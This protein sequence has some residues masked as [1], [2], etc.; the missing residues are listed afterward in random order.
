MLL[1]DF[2]NLG[3]IVTFEYKFLFKIFSICN[4]PLK[5]DI[6]TET[7]IDKD[8]KHTLLPTYV[9]II[10]TEN[11]T[12]S[13][14]ILIFDTNVTN[15]FLF[16]IAKVQNRT[17]KYCLFVE[18][19]FSILLSIDS[20]RNLLSFIDNNRLKIYLN[21]KMHIYY[22]EKYKRYAIADKDI[23]DILQ[24]RDTP[25]CFKNKKRYSSKKS[26]ASRKKRKSL[27]ILPQK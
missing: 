18:K 22:S 2:I 4:I 8:D 7:S 15:C 26:N 16:S 1:I 17:D 13:K 14:T 9:K 20:T 21:K 5:T 19:K 27:I 6:F 25:Y 10:G 3:N 24:E 23:E 12:N 11:I